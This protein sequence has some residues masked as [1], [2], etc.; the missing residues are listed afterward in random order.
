[1]ITIT[2][3]KP[4]DEIKGYLDRCNSVYIIGCGTCTTMLHTG[5]KTEVLAMKDEL[6]A[7]GKKVPGWMVIPT[8]C[9][10]LT[11]EA[12]AETAKD[13]E[14]SDCLLVMSCSYGVQTVSL[15]VDKPIYPAQNTLFIGKEV[16]PGQFIDL[17]LQCGRCVLGKT[18]GICPL[19]RC[20]KGLMHGPCGGSVEGKCEVSTEVPCA[21]Q[22]IIDRLTVQGQLDRLDGEEIEPPQDW[23]TSNS[24]G[25]RRITVET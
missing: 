16:S 13:I 20:A 8:A 23:S 21:W 15:H 19:V 25:P 10:E 9:D 17:C 22:L 24:G 18:A 14:A 3:Q 6:E 11:K 5:G 2:E 12:L 1:M 4:L 7:A